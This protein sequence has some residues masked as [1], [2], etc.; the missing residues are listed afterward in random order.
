VASVTII[1]AAFMAGLGFGSHVGGVLSP[2]LSPAESFR[3]F[4]VAQ[5]L[6]GSFALASCAFFYDLLYV[7]AYWLFAGA[8][9]AALTQFLA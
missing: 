2:R 5:L 7:R 3:I 8:W 6:L 1:V 4:G 9:R